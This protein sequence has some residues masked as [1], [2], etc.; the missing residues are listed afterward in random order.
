MSSL[1][2]GGR[3]L[4]IPHEEQ[5]Q[6]FGVRVSSARRIGLELIDHSD[7]SD[8]LKHNWETFKHPLPRFT[9]PAIAEQSQVT[10]P[11]D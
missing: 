10:S 11:K 4:Y 3:E 6:A 5:Y 7:A 9:L 8:R 1:S 2:R